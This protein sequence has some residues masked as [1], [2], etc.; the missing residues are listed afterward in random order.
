MLELVLIL[1][2]IN[3]QTVTKEMF[4]NIMIMF[5]MRNIKLEKSNKLTLKIE[6]III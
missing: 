4:L 2:T 3:M 1:F 6:L 5:I